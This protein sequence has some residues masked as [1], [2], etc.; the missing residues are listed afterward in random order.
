M[1]KFLDLAD[2]LVLAIASHI[3]RSGD[4]L[5]L[6]LV[7]RKLYYLIIPELYRYIVLG[8]IEDHSSKDYFTL[9]RVRGPTCWD[10]VRLR[11]LCS[12]LKNKPSH[13]LVVESLILELDAITLHESF[14]LSDIMLYLPCSKSLCLNGKRL[15]G[16]K[17]GLEPSFVSPSE[18]GQRLRSV[19]GTLG[20][21]IID[22]DR[23]MEFRDAS[24]IGSLHHLVALKQLGLQS[25]ILLGEWDHLTDRQ[26][27]DTD[28]IYD[29]TLL[30]SIVPPSLQKLQISCWMDG[31]Q[32]FWGRVIALR[33]RSLMKQHPSTLPELQNI[34]V[35][36]PI[37]RNAAHDVEGPG[38]KVDWSDFKKYVAEE[39]WQKVARVLTEIALKEHRNIIVKYQQGS[40]EGSRSWGETATGPADVPSQDSCPAQ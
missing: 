4:K 7:N 20:S 14:E 24:G 31:H 30:A 9:R 12:V 1:A 35:Y 21:L 15:A 19:S 32:D 5:Q 27:D 38:T 17:G 10:T 33:L 11:H 13:E 22:I 36:Y 16:R 28:V 8:S 37:K 23:D 18:I 26:S 25:H 29:E 3:P 34:T 6:V 39:R 2:E 40:P